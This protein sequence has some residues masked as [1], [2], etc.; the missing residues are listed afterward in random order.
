MLNNIPHQITG[1]RS[2]LWKSEWLRVHQP[3]LRPC[4]VQEQASRR[5]LEHLLPTH[6]RYA[7][8]RRAVQGFIRAQQRWFPSRSRLGV[9]NFHGTS[10]LT[11][12][13]LGSKCR[14]QK[15][16]ATVPPNSELQEA[17]WKTTAAGQGPRGSTLHEW[18]GIERLTCTGPEQGPQTATIT[19]LELQD[20]LEPETVTGSSRQHEGRSNARSRLV[21]R[22]KYSNFEACLSY[23]IRELYEEYGTKVFVLTFL[24]GPAKQLER[25]PQ[26]NVRYNREA[27]TLE[28]MNRQSLSTL[29]A[30]WQNL[31]DHG[32]LGR[33]IH[34]VR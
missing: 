3:R 25:T 13:Q 32:V 11:C 30:K 9:G 6:T 27:L 18:N 24:L 5:L 12:A 28:F 16:C 26:P 10:G 4:S 1:P 14:Y 2:L 15:N 21:C 31:G 29:Q 33:I 20:L 17:H 23:V 8:G 19:C 22:P 34:A 7:A